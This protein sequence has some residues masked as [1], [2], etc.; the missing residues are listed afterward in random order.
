[1]SEDWKKYSMNELQVRAQELEA[2]LTIVREASE[3]LMVRQSRDVNEW[4]RK[5][6]DSQRQMKGLREALPKLF[7]HAGHE[8]GADLPQGQSIPECAFWG[9]FHRCSCGYTKARE[10]IE[11]ALSASSIPVGEGECG[12]CPSHHDADVPHDQPETQMVVCPCR[13]SI[14]PC[15]NCGEHVNGLHEA[16]N[17]HCNNCTTCS[18]TITPR[19]DE[20]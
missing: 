13:S 16:E 4:S 20:Q 5:Y 1:M 18:G 15:N 9:D 2:E 11:S 14:T 6:Y 8:H 17:Y 10:A 12:E 7:E 19:G 3:K